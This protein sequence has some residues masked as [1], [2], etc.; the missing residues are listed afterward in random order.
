MTNPEN[1]FD[2]TMWDPVNPEHAIE[3]PFHGSEAIMASLAIPPF[4]NEDGTFYVFGASHFCGSCTFDAEGRPF[5]KIKA[6][7]DPSFLREL[8][9]HAKWIEAFQAGELPT[10]EEMELPE[11]QFSHAPYITM[12]K[13]PKLSDRRLDEVLEDYIADDR[14]VISDTQDDKGYWDEEGLYWYF[15]PPLTKPTSIVYVADDKIVRSDTDKEQLQRIVEQLEEASDIPTLGDVLGDNPT[16][17][18]E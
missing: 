13:P 10:R 7:F 2:R 9:E 8:E 3:D 14:A 15:S 16:I 18:E 11:F 1:P 4:R 5:I 17:I 12:D 6:G